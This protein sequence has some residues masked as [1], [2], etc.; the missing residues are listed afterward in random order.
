[1]VV[2]EAMTWMTIVGLKGKMRRD[3]KSERVTSD[4]A[5]VKTTHLSALGNFL[6]FGFSREKR[7]F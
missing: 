2:C 3:L 1:M 7:M 6:V 5:V 4:K